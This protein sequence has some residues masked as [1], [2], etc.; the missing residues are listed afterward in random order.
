MT[1]FPPLAASI[2]LLEDSFEAAK[3]DYAQLRRIADALQHHSAP[4]A[5]RL[6]IRVAAELFRLKRAAGATSSSSSPLP[7]RSPLLVLLSR[8]GLDA[9][10]GRPLYRYRLG[11]DGYNQ[12]TALVCQRA[13]RLSNGNGSDAAL[14]VL[15][16][17]AWFRREYGGGIR[18]YRELGAAIGATL[19][20][21]EW[22]PLIELGLKWWKRPVV[23]RASGRHWLLTIAVE[24]GLSIGLQI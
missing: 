19:E 13:A 7:A 22:P 23:K 4:G 12:L 10:D 8:F 16:A 11:A 14:L 17:S 3:G 18:K 9:P 6:R 24:G 20:E 1:A 5:Q 2:K 21:R 15:W